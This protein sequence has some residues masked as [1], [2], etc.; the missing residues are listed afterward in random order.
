MNNRLDRTREFP[1]EKL[2]RPGKA[3]IP[4]Q[5]DPTHVLTPE[6]T[7]TGRRPSVPLNVRLR[8]LR[9][10]GRWSVFGAIV[11]F[12]CWVMWAAQSQTTGAGLVLFLIFLIAVG[13]F[14]VSRLAGSVVVER[15]LGRTRRGAVLSHVAIGLFLTIAGLSLLGQ[16]EWVITAWNQVRG[17]R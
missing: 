9:R 3:A 5:R 11:L 17:M 1:T 14:A 2:Y 4:E 16:V 7:M 10:G 8:N 12:V 13:L 15:L 6:P